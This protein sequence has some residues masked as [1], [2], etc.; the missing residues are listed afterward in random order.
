MSIHDYSIHMY[1]T[2]R[3]PCT[4]QIFSHWSPYS[5]KKVAPIASLSWNTKYPYTSIYYNENEIQ[6]QALSLVNKNCLQARL[7]VHNELN[8]TVSNYFYVTRIRKPRCVI[9]SIPLHT[10]VVDANEHN[11]HI[12]EDIRLC[13]MRQQLFTINDLHVVRKRS[14]IY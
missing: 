11:F 4:H 14:R 10:I 13:K 2:C 8:E 12:C 9:E 6:K 7:S 1:S 3:F 5:R